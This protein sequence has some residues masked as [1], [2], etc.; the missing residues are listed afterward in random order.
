MRFKLP[1][2]KVIDET[3]W[4]KCFIGW[5]AIIHEHFI[6]LETAEHRKIEKIGYADTWEYRF[7]EKEELTF[8]GLCNRYYIVLLLVVAG[9]LAFVGFGEPNPVKL[10]VSFFLIMLAIAYMFRK[11][12]TR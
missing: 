12:M 9:I 7:L 4:H 1:K 5:P 11:I 10:F 8:Q 2:K 3:R 6:W